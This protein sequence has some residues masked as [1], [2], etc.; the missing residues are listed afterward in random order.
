VSAGGQLQRMEA[1]AGSPKVEGI[2]LVG[3]QLLMVTDADD[4][5]R[6]SQLLAID[7]G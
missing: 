7:L 3:T 5:A 4:P 6:A 1:I 2:A